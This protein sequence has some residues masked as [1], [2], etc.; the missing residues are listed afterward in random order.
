VTKRLS[1]LLITV[2]N[3]RRDYYN[4][5]FKQDISNPEF[6]RQKAIVIA[7]YLYLGTDSLISLIELGLFIK[8]GKIVIYYPDGFYRRGNI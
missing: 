8:T 7:I 4:A 6:Y 2:L 1:L 3:P 5:N